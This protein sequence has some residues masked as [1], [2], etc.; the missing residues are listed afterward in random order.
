MSLRNA[1]VKVLDP[2]SK[3]PLYMQII[4]Q[5]RPSDV[6]KE[7]RVI[8]PE[9]IGEGDTCGSKYI[10]AGRPQRELR[11]GKV[12]EYAKGYTLL[13]DWLPSTIILAEIPGK[14]GQYYVVDGQHRLAA[15]VEYKRPRE[16]TCIII[17]A[18]GRSQAQTDEI[19]AAIFEQINKIVTPVL[20][21][22]LAAHRSNSPAYL[23]FEQAQEAAK[24]GLDSA[25]AY[26]VRMTFTHSVKKNN[27]CAMRWADPLAAWDV[28]IQRGISPKSGGYTTSSILALWRS[29]AG[30]EAVNVAMH[31]I[32]AMEKARDLL[33]QNT[34]KQRVRGL[35][36][37][38]DILVNT[39]NPISPS[40]TPAKAR[41]ARDYM[42]QVAT[43][44]HL[45]RI[46][47]LFYRGNMLRLLLGFARGGVDFGHGLSMVLKRLPNL[48]ASTNAA[49][50][51]FTTH[52]VILQLYP[53]VEKG[54]NNGV[55]GARLVWPKSL[56][57]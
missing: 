17:K 52:A 4:Q 46:D 21:D 6:T 12:L 44:S 48:I 38:G 9:D 53:V 10:I 24:V 13:P 55:R 57:L 50:L 15:L 56:P 29:P 40:R 8:S 5:L 51:N 54:L 35:D 22:F 36:E 23:A 39:F 26:P 42:R 30:A 27:P 20:S 11:R 47:P 2:K 28:I 37:I 25:T 43:R 3:I 41:E 32:A 45:Q 1:P 16:F 19:I 33:A 31:L 18:T 7:D 49:D 34:P 14:P